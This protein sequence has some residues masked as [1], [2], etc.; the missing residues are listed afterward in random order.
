MQSDEA[1]DLRAEMDQFLEG[2]THLFCA[3]ANALER[4]G[5]LDKPALQRAIQEKINWLEHHRADI[6]VATPLLLAKE[7][8][9]DPPPDPNRPYDGRP[10]DHLRLVRRK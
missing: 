1:G 4:S 10:G 6:T 3:L 9:I 7:W 5:A 8:L 2:Q